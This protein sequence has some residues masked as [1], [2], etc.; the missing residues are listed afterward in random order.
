MRK[1]TNPKFLVEA[2]GDEIKYTLFA[3][4]VLLPAQA[5]LK[6]KRKR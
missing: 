5:L 3:K 4:Q 2:N 6:Q 1:K